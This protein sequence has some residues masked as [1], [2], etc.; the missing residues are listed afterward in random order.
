[1]AMFKSA[2]LRLTTGYLAIIMALSIGCSL[3]LY[4]VS[5]NE[6]AQSAQRPVDLY[7]V[8]FGLTNSSEVNDLQLLQLDNDLNRLKVNLLLFNIAVLVVGGGV[9]YILARRTL[10]PIEES[11]EMQKR[12]TG[13]ASHELR[14]PLTAMQTEIEV[15]LRNP[16]LSKKEAVSLLNSNLEEVG[17]LKSLS[18]GLLTLAMTDDNSVAH[19]E[20]SVTC[21]VDRAIDQVSKPA[22]TRKIKLNKKIKETILLGN[23]QQLTNLIAIL[24]DNAIKYS[25]PNSQVKIESRRS[26]KQAQISVTDHGQGIAAAD[27]PHIFERFYR[28]DTSRNQD[29]AHGYGLGLAIAN[30]IINLHHGSIEVKSSSEKGSIFTVRL[31]LV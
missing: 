25:P 15:A 1:M 14:T 23:P 9:S 12:F 30:K 16:E 19:Q 17:K 21:L 13:D 10:E 27:L 26:N 7:N 22:V 31:P 29:T 24:L 3:A 28:A 11:L 8:I 6:L 2:A 4:H 5:S 20:I 18:E